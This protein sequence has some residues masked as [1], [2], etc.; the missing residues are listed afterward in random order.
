MHSPPP[1]VPAD[2]RISPSGPYLD[3]GPTG[4]IRAGYDCAVDSPP[5]VTTISL[6]PTPVTPGFVAR[7]IVGDDPPEPVPINVT[8][9]EWNSG[10]VLWI[11]W[12][13]SGFG[14]TDTDET[15]V[16]F[17]VEPVI[18]IGNGEW[19]VIQASGVGGTYPAYPAGE[20]ASFGP[21]NLAG[22]VAVRIT[23]PVSPPMV[24]LAYSLT[25]VDSPGSASVIYFG[26][27]PIGVGPTSS[28]L[29]CYEI[30]GSLAFQLPPESVLTPLSGP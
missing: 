14:L 27:L 23:D 18:D 6:D 1:F 11:N 8:F 16:I 9:T 13:F 5:D 2:L 20:A 10:D 7:Q 25:G 4:I 30:D 21:L 19:E 29:A 12:H 17:M 28:W 3:I 15:F 22:N 24:Q 26:I